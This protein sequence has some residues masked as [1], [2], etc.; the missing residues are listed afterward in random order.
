[1]KKVLY[2][3]GFLFVVGLLAGPRDKSGST[4]DSTSASS[5]SS[6]NSSTSTRASSFMDDVREKVIKD[7]EREY[8]I[9]S[10]SGTRIDRC[11]QAGMVAAAYLQAHNQPSYQSWK[12]RE[13]ADCQR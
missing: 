12:M 2:I 1:M 4:T 7:A 11:V 3:L 5:Y 9:A 13:E 8:Q 10:A 6:H